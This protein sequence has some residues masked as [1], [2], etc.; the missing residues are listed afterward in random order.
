MTFSQMTSPWGKQV[1]GF[2]PPIFS[3]SLTNPSGLLDAGSLCPHCEE[4]QCAGLARLGKAPTLYQMG[5]ILTLEG[6][7]ED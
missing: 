3:M 1:W 7:C 5:T 2:L 4:Q 6:G